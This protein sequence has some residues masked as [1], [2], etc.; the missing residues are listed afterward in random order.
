MNQ[1]QSINCSDCAGATQH[2]QPGAPIRAIFYLLACRHHARA[3]AGIL[4]STWNPVSA[5]GT[6]N[7]FGQVGT[8]AS[9]LPLT[10][11]L[12]MHHWDAGN[13]AEMSWMSTSAFQ[14]CNSGSIFSV[15]QT[16]KTHEKDGRISPD[17]GPACRSLDVLPGRANSLFAFRRA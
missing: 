16:Q 1:E 3:G 17:S 15:V 2:T 14:V 13:G 8:E 10:L 4:V 11:Q 9:H 5:Q 6:S 12:Q 7:A